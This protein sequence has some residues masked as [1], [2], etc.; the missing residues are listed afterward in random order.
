MRANL[1]YMISYPGI[2][3]LVAQRCDKKLNSGVL[4]A[5]STVSAQSAEFVFFTVVGNLYDFIK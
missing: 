4:T 2:R 3:D 5:L 1:F